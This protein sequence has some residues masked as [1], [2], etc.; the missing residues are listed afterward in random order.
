MAGNRRGEAA[1]AALLD[2]GRDAFSHQRYEEV[3]IVDL[4]RTL[5]VAAGSISYHFGGKRG[6]YLAVIE[7]AFDEFRADILATRGPA[8]EWL[9]RF[10][11][12]LLDRA[13]QHPG[14]YELMVADVADI[15]VRQIRDRSFDQITEQLAL[16]LTGAEA[17]PVL[18]AAI[19]GCIASIEGLV[20]HW[21]HTDALTRD[22]VRELIVTNYIGA[23]ISAIRVD[24]TIRIREEIMD[25]ILADPQALAE[26]V[27]P[28][29][30][31]KLMEIVMANPTI[32]SMFLPVDPPVSA[33]TN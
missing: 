26:F 1:R 10:I 12:S 21:L 5:G 4:A 33:D 13:E 14:G 18:R 15:Q 22:Q 30:R 11:D 8:L 2:A 3:S 27:P 7:Q 23:V 28:E 19:T 6:F 20:V 17:G 9:N 24:P 25:S 16:E 31:Y 32:L 29:L